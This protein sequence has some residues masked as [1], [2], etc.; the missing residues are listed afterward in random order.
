MTWFCILVLTPQ[1]LHPVSLPLILVT[2]DQFTSRAVCFEEIL[3][4][5]Q[6]A[7]LKIVTCSAIIE[8]S[9]TSRFIRCKNH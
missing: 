5:T 3:L 7:A 8:Y 2:H 6:T 1:A 4:S 9:L